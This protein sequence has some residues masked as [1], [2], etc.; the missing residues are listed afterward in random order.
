MLL[1]V[2]KNWILGRR[3]Y[4]NGAK[5]HIGLGQLPNIK[6]FNELRKYDNV[7]VYVGGPV[8]ECQKGQST[9]RSPPDVNTVLKLVG[10]GYLM[11][12]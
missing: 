4:L 1:P 10:R 3:A 2:E 11:L 12:V 6:S 5:V 8:D 9:I 7:D